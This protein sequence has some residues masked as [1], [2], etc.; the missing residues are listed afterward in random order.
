[1]RQHAAACGLVVTLDI[2]VS[3][4]ADWVSTRSHEKLV[5]RTC[6]N[7]T[8]VL[9]GF[10]LQTFGL[11]EFFILTP[12]RSRAYLQPLCRDHEPYLAQQPPRSSRLGFPP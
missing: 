3:A 9:E 12:S 7:N 8:G 4:S 1:M 11:C 5:S 2:L 10:S 6:E